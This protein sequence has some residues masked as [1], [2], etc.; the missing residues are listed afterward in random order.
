MRLVYADYMNSYYGRLAR[1]QLALQQAA[2]SNAAAEGH[3]VRASLSSAQRSCAG[4]RPA[5]DAPR[6]SGSCSRRACTT[7]RSSELRYAQRAWG[8][9]PVIEAT[10]A[11]VYHE[12]GD[13][14]RAITI[15]AARVSAVPGRRRRRSAAGDPAGD[16]PADLL[17]LDPPECRARTISIPTSWRRSSR[18]S[19]RSIPAAHSAANAWGLMQIVPDDRSAARAGPSASAASRRRC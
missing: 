17:G 6:S 3:A 10:M 7:T 13:L 19:R 4:S 5:A 1:K 12:K 8:T 15:D 11:W 16:L 9:S 18:R 14:R 2:L